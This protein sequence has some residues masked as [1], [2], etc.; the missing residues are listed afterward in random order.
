MLKAS[1]LQNIPLEHILLIG[2]AGMG[3]T[4]I[5][6]NIAQ[7]LQTNFHNIQGTSITKTSDIISILTNLKPYDIIFIDEIHVVSTEI[8]EV[9]YTALEGAYINILIGKN[10]NNKII[11]INL[12]PFT[13]I[14]ATNKVGLLTKAL[15]SRI[16]IVLQLEKYLM[17]DIKNLIFMTCKNLN[18]ELAPEI[19]D[20]LSN[21]CR[22][23]PRIII[24]MVKQIYNYCLATNIKLTTVTI[25]DIMLFLNI[26][27]YGLN[28][29]EINYLKL[30]VNEKEAV[31]LSLDTISSRL[32]EEI[33]NIE[34]HCEPLLLELLLITK[35]SKG[36][37]LTKKGYEYLENYFKNK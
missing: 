2:P 1:R 19:I 3:K 30:F 20:S 31:F 29:L 24:N 34:Y 16:P 25:K 26:Y 9:L 6:K 36:R 13:L 7:E 11:K 5:A 33:K 4:T 28:Q 12:P 37:T 14:A 27:Y 10:F 22:N 23:T 15:I 17:T 18:W 8:L 35:T 21:Y 32:N